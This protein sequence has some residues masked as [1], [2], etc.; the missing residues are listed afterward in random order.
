MTA[1]NVRV[2][3]ARLSRNVAPLGYSMSAARSAVELP[4]PRHTRTLSYSLAGGEV[5]VG[6]VAV[7]GSSHF[8]VLEE[9]ERE[10]V[11]KR[12][13]KARILRKP[14]LEDPGALTVR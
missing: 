2:E 9:V 10:E 4:A 12:K 5:V 11:G 13:K 8:C 14:T 7:G 3:L 1:K 6:A